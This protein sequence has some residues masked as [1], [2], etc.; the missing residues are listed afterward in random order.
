MGNDRKGVQSE[1]VN[2]GTD[3]LLT[4]PDLQQIVGKNEV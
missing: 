3:L 2:T 1:S 4:Q